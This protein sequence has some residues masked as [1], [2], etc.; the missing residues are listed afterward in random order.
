M[1]SRD[2]NSQ[3]QPRLER[4][5]TEKR[6]NQ[7][8]LL[9]CEDNKGKKGGKEKKGGKNGC[10]F[11]IGKLNVGFNRQKFKIYRVEEKVRY[12]VDRA[13]DRKADGEASSFFLFRILS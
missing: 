4:A 6:H 8:L 1:W 9:W 12:T 11:E 7:V 2:G 10:L 3:S 13:I 5:K